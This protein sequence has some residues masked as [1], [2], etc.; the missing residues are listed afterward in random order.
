MEVRKDSDQMMWSNTSLEPTADAVPIHM[1][2]DSSIEF[3]VSLP[4]LT[5]LLLSSIR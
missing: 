3:G 2:R 5:R 4:R 1:N